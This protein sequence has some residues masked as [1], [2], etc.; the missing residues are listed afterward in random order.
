MAITITVQREISDEKATIRPSS[1]ATISAMRIRRWRSQRPERLEPWS[2][3]SEPVSTASTVPSR[4]GQP[5][6]SG[7]RERRARGLGVAA[8]VEE[9]V[10][11]RTGPGDVGAERAER[12]QVVGE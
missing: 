1:T 7:A 9:P 4:H 10:D 6:P 3:V 5:Q 2:I 8:V 12:E 11:G